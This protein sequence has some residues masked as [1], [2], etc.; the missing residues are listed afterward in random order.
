MNSFV[1]SLI[2]TNVPI[3]IGGLIAWLVSLNVQVPEGSEEGLVV[4]VTGLII[5]GYYTLVRALEKRWPSFGILLGTRQE[6]EYPGVPPKGEGRY[7]ADHPL[8]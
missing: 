2:R 1:V 7:R 6:P 3:V 8:D 5:A 4:G